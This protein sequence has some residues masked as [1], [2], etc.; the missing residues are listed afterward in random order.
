[1]RLS[2]GPGNRAGG[3]F[4]ARFWGIVDAGPDT[5]LPFSAA[6]IQG[7]YRGPMGK[8]GRLYSLVPVIKRAKATLI[9]AICPSDGGSI[10]HML[11]SSRNRQ[12]RCVVTPNKS[13]L[14]AMLAGLAITMTTAQAENGRSVLP[15]GLSDNPIGRAL[16]FD[17]RPCYETERNVMIGEMPWW[18]CEEAATAYIMKRRQEEEQ[19]RQAALAAK[20]RSDEISAKF[21]AAAKQGNYRRVSFNELALSPKRLLGVKVRSHCRAITASTATSPAQCSSEHRSTRYRAIMVWRR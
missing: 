21:D 7:L 14:T 16:Y 17:N 4:P 15:F 13:H 1:V 6:L 3:A 8:R 5:T 9:A 2:P 20:A 10:L 12:T 11:I 19:Q 18:R